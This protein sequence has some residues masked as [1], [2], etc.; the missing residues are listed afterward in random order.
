MFFPVLLYFSR[1]GAQDEDRGGIRWKRD[2]WNP[3][4]GSH[5]VPVFLGGAE[6]GI[7]TKAYLGLNEEEQEIS[8]IGEKEKNHKNNISVCFNRNAGNVFWDSSKMLVQ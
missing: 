1:V 2:I 5:G 7:F 3:Y 4:K 8:L 6:I